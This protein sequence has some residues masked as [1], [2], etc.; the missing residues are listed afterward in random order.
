MNSNFAQTR[1][2]QNIALWVILLTVNLLQY[3]TYVGV[4]SKR[5][6]VFMVEYVNG[7]LFQSS[8]LLPWWRKHLQKEAYGDFEVR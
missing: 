1:Y 4:T 8:I 7:Y 5:C 6:F 3:A 2:G